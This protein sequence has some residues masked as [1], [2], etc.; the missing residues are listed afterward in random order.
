MTLHLLMPQETV[1]VKCPQCGDPR[2]ISVRQR[3]RLVNSGKSFK[4]HICRT[5]Q[6]PVVTQEHLDWWRNRYPMWWIKETAEM[7]WGDE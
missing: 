5:M 3:R 2:E 1:T 4:C 7:I 6:D